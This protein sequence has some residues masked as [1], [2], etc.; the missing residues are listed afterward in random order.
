VVIVGRPANPDKV[1][2][3]VTRLAWAKDTP[4]GGALEQ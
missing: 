3:A 4:A 2:S 1:A